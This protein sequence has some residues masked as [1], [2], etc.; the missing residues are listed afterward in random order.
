MKKWSLVIIAVFFGSIFYIKWGV[1]KTQTLEEF[2]P[3]N[4]NHV[5]SVEIR[6]GRSG[7]LL[8]L[9]DKDEVKAFIKGVKDIKFIPLKNQKERKG[10]LYWVTFYEKGEQTLSFSGSQIKH[11]YYQTDPDIDTYIAKQ[12]DLG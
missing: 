8:K 11:R 3:G 9:E 6:D 4:I 5:T 12:F 1:A 2:Y 10:Y 7:K